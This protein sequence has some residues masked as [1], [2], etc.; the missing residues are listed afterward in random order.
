MLKGKLQFGGDWLSDLFKAKAPPFIGVDISSSSVKM[1][2]WPT[3]ER[4][5]PTQA[6]CHRAVAQGR[7][8]RRQHHEPRGGGDSVRR[9]WTRRIS[10]QEPRD[11]FALCGV[12]LK[13]TV[14]ADLREDGGDAGRDRNHYI[15]FTP[16]K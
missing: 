3:A 4:P 2:S 10:H 6:L 11:G 15:P 5:H 14:P 12:I 13:I 9:G 8:S 16:R 7:G 1:V